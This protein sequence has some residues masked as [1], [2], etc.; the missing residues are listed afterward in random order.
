MTPKTREKQPLQYA[1]TQGLSRDDLAAHVVTELPYRE[2]V[3]IPLPFV[4]VPE[5]P[6]RTGP[7]APAPPAPPRS[8]STPDSVWPVRL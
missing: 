3:S 5:G 1:S 8:R 6:V 7:G 2:T 4:V